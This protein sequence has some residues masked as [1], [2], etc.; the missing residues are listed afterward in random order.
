MKLRG[1]TLSIVNC[2]LVNNEL[3]YYMTSFW[4]SIALFCVQ[5]IMKFSSP[6]S[7]QQVWFCFNVVQK[8][9]MAFH[10]FSLTVSLLKVVNVLSKQFKHF[11]Q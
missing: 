6:L 4:L 11:A 8:C 3:E 7:L 9:K 2:V 10:T 5:K 1:Y